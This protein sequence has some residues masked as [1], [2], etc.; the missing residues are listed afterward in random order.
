MSF[1]KVNNKLDFRNVKQTQLDGSQTDKAAFSELKSAYRQY[2]TTTILSDAY[3]HF[4]Q[5]L[6]SEDRPTKVEY[7]QATYPA[8]HR[9]N[10]RADNNGDL[11][12]TYFTL[13]EY[14]SKKT[15]VFYYTVEGIGT[16]P[17]IGDVEYSINL[18]L[19]DAASVVSFASKKA[20]GNLPEFSVIGNNLL[21]SYVDLEYYQFGEAE[22]VNVGSTGF[23]ADAKNAGESFYVGGV[24][25]QYD[26]DGSPIYNGN[27]LKGLLYNP[28][29]ASFDVERD[30][31]TVNADN[32]SVNLDSLIGKDPSIINVAMPVAGE[33]YSISLPIDTKRFQINV[34]DHGARYTISYVSNG[35]YITKNRGVVYEEE[36]LVLE[37]GTNTIY[38]TTTKNNMTMEIVTWK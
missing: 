27:K 32:I 37:S 24:E 31:V 5:E 11:A 1:N 13:Q 36:N 10:F 17:G 29:T 7:Y 15:H 35:P 6:D 28:Y 16:A 19:N 38:F 21:S 8:R 26:V 22:L 14:I 3:T 25:L 33:E 9:I 34:R 18:S 20:I 12:G 2:A 23:L 4:V 30:E